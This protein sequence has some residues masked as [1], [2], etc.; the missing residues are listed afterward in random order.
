MFITSQV[1]ILSTLC[2][3]SKRTALKEMIEDD[4]HVRYFIT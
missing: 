1:T 2:V 4:F 3:F